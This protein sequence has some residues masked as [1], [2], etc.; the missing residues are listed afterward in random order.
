MSSSIVQLTNMSALFTVCPKSTLAASHAAANKS[1]EYVDRTGRQTDG[2][3]TVTLR[4]PL[5]AA[6]VI[7]FIT[8]QEADAMVCKCATVFIVHRTDV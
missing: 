6:V 1:A 2:R 7:V 5:D 8:L 4:F 3:Q